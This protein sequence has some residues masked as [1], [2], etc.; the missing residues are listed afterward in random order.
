MWTGNH[1]I[2]SGPP[3]HGHLRQR[4]RHHIFSLLST[5][6]VLLHC[7]VAP[8]PPASL[9]THK[10]VG[11]LGPSEPG[12]PWPVAETCPERRAARCRWMNWPACGHEVGVPSC[13]RFAHIV[14]P[15]V[16]TSQHSSVGLCSVERRQ[17]SACFCRRPAHLPQPVTCRGGT[18]EL[19]SGR[20]AT[21]EEGWGVIVEGGIG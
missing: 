20:H 2:T 8:K 16:A 7:F 18:A 5:A 19:F 3:R 12:M 14:G 21:R 6:A 17:L 9:P 4:T 15:A 10:P 13:C 11:A 1:Q